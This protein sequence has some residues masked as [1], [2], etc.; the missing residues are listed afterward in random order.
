LLPWKLLPLPYQRPSHVHPRCCSSYVGRRS[1]SLAA[2]LTPFTC[3]FSLL[4]ALSRRLLLVGCRPPELGD[5]LHHA[6]PSIITATSI[7]T[8]ST[9]FF[10]SS[11]TRVHVTPM[12]LS[13]ATVSCSNGVAVCGVF[14]GCIYPFFVLLNSIVI[15]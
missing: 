11:P 15:L 7:G 5:L 13:L 8:T 10:I 3:A 9:S 14:A 4:A 6:E 1:C 12:R 2:M